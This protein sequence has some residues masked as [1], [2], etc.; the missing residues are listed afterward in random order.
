[1]RMHFVVTSA[2]VVVSALATFVISGVDD[3]DWPK[4]QTTAVASAHGAEADNI[5]WP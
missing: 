5:D 3:I 1:M 2:V 4:A